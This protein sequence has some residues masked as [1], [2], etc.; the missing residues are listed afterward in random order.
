MMTQD[1]AMETDI[2]TAILTRLDTLTKAMLAN[3][4]TLTLD[5]ACIYAGISQSTMYKLTS[6]GQIRHYK[7]RGKMIYFRRAE[8]EQ[9]LINPN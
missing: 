5:E 1:N 3:K 8:L 2:L 9:D 4:D 6:T 7:P